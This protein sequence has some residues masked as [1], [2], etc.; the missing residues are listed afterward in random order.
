MDRALALTVTTAEDAPFL[1]WGG[2]SW[3]GALSVAKDDVVLIGEL[4]VAGAMVQRVLEIDETYERGSAHEF[5]ISY[6]GGRPGGSPGLARQHY[7]RALELSSG[8]RASVHLALAEAVSIQEQNLTE[9]KSLI[10]AALAVEPDK[11]PNLRLVNVI[12]GRRALWLETRI[13]D[14]FLD[15]PGT[16]KT[17]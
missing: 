16:E 7:R 1:Y 10:G 5:L 13:A 12:A 6:E 3:A 8:Q 4:P 14:L 17:E 11:V 2:A 15:A 9:F